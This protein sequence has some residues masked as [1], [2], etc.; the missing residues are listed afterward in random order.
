MDPQHA[1]IDLDEI[2]ES[3]VLQDLNSAYGTYIND[4][5]IDNGAVRLRSGD[6]IRFGNSSTLYEFIASIEPCVSN[7]IRITSN[8]CATFLGS[9]FV[10]LMVACSHSTLL[11]FCLLK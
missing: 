1:V 2:G 3:F 10:K 4:Y 5:R 7:P 6:V 11:M 8:L 9:F